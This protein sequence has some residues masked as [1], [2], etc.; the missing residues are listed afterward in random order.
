[1]V[2]SKPPRRRLRILVDCADECY[3]DAEGSSPIPPRG[4]LVV[5]V[6]P[7]PIRETPSMSA[8]SKTR[9][10]RTPSGYYIRVEGRGTLRESPA[11]HAFAGHVLESEPG[12]VVLD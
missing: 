6:L 11:V 9:V 10:S 3:S 2:I 12:T 4:V 5:M 8:L 1:M 7:P